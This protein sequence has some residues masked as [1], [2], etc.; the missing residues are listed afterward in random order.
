[1]TLA[2]EANLNGVKVNPDA[3][4]YEISGHLVQKCGHIDT[5]TDTGPIYALPGPLK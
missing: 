5:Q 4:G 1:M 2:F 3:I